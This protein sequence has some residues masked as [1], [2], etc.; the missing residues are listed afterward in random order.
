M[1]SSRNFSPIIFF[2]LAA[3]LVSLG[4]QF[5]TQFT[6]DGSNDKPKDNPTPGLR[7]GSLRAAA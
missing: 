6:N 7:L 2:F 1:T 4:C 5:I 3:T